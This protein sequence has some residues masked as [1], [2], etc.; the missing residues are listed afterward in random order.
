[1]NKRE[2]NIEVFSQTF[3][4]EIAELNST[5]SIAVARSISVP[6]SRIVFIIGVMNLVLLVCVH[7][8]MS[9]RG[10]RMKSSTIQ[11]CQGGVDVTPGTIVAISLQ[12]MHDWSLK[13]LQFQQLSYMIWVS[14]LMT[15]CSSSHVYQYTN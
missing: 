4:T 14:N 3:L 1:M 5:M 10:K 11:K 7:F 8:K 13:C 15:S 2:T 12:N 9:P 6:R